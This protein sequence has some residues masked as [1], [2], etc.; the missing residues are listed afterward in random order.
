MSVCKC[1]FASMELKNI[2]HL[3]ACNLNI[4]Y[5]KQDGLCGV[6]INNMTNIGDV[7]I[8]YAGA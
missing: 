8:F 7:S 6:K 2:V 4:K 3:S 5:V 1:F